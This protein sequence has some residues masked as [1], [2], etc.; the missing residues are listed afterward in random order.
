MSYVFIS[1]YQ[2]KKK[3]R[4]FFLS[5]LSYFQTSKDP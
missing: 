3:S 1:F 4:T 5:I 2:K